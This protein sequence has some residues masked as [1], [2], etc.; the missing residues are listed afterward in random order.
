ML[1][2]LMCF[3]QILALAGLARALVALLVTTD[4]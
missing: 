2:H 1:L 3:L 4:A